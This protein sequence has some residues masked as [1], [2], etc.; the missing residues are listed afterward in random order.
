MSTQSPAF[1]L[2]TTL[3]RTLSRP[4]FHPSSVLCT[5]CLSTLRPNE[6]PPLP[7]LSQKQPFSTHP[8]LRKKQGG[9]GASKNTVAVNTAKLSGDN[10]DPLDFSALETEIGQIAEKL[11][12]DVQG[13]KPGGINIEAVEDAKVVLKSVG[14]K[15]GRKATLQAQK[16]DRSLKGDSRDIAKERSETK[17]LVRYMK[18]LGSTLVA[19]NLSPLP[20]PP[21]SSS[22]STSSHQSL[23]IHIPIPPTTAESRR[24]AITAV[25]TRGETALFELREARG[26]QKK[27]LRRMEMARKVGPDLLRKAEKEL[28]RVN[29]GGVG[30]VEKIVEERRKALAEN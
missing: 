9:K 26:A 30:K 12:E 2:L 10:L 1:L 25:S 23:E 22:S 20:S 19:L 3:T 18:P 24:S 29:K 4:R 6:Q 13:I 7:I 16:I 27:R 11:K 15:D 28:E 14:L 5:Q 17:E 8:P 21:P